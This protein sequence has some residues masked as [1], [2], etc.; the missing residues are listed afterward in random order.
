MQ[1]T[2][3]E[4]PF[5]AVQNQLLEQLKKGVFLTVQPKDK[6]NTMTI[7]WG[8]S[9]RIWDK[10]NFTVAVR[11]SRYTFELMEHSEY[12][13]ISVPKKDT[14]KK[15]LAYCGT[16]SGR[17]EDKLQTG[18][19]T[20]RYLENFSVPIIEECALHILCKIAYKQAMDPSLIQLPFVQNKYPTHDYHTLY[21]GEVIGVY[22]STL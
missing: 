22:E 12:F 4:V 13:T 20:A 18:G 3:R 14:L 16:I 9:G 17:D 7:S 2:L 1:N 19:V 8:N 11:H 5:E 21:Y 15:A 10:D 6:P